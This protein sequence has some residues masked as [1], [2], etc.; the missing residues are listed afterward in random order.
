MGGWKASGV[1]N[2]GHISHFSPPVKM[3]R[4]GRDLL[5]E[6]EPLPTNKPLV[7]WAASTRRLR[8]DRI[9]VKKEKK[10]K[11]HQQNLRPS[12]TPMLSGLKIL[13]FVSRVARVDA[14][15]THGGR[16][17]WWAGTD[18]SSSRYIG[19]HTQQSTAVSHD[20]M[21]RLDAVLSCRR[22]AGRRR[23]QLR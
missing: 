20:G 9:P 14:A 17:H 16:W 15:K 5:S 12:D 6:Y 4:D 18:Y 19:V 13:T 10:E 7:W 8:A 22:A 3:G 23:P 1:E 21:T 11:V 2:W